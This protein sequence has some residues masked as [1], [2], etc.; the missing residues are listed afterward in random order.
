MFTVDRFNN[1]GRMCTAPGD[2]TPRTWRLMRAVQGERY[3]LRNAVTGEYRTLS[4]WALT[5]LY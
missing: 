2:K 5:S 3:M 1:V 4:V